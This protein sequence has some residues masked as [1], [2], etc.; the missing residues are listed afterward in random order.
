[1]YTIFVYT[2]KECTLNSTEFG[3]KCTLVSHY[4]E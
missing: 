2:Y 3:N 1:M 4:L